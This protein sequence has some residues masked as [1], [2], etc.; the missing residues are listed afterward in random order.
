MNF[1]SAPTPS[2][3]EEFYSTFIASIRSVGT[4]CTLAAV[5]IYLHRQGYVVGD[6]KRSLALI[7]QQ[8]TI[9][10]FLFTKLI[11]CNQDWSDQPCPDV[12]KSLEDVWILMIWP[13]YVVITGLAI[14]WVVAKLSNTP[15]HQIHAVL[16]ACAFGNSTGLPITLLTVVHENFPKTSDLGRIDPN[17][18]LSVYLLLYPVLQ[19]G[20]GGW[21]LAPEEN[22]TNTNNNNNNHHD[23]LEQQQ[24]PAST[25]ITG[26]D[27]QSQ[28][29]RYVTNTDGLGPLVSPPL[30]TSGDAYADGYASSFQ[31]FTL[32][33]S[34]PKLLA[35]NVLNNRATANFYKF[36][37]RGMTET[38]ASLYMSVQEDLYLY[39]QMVDHPDDLHSDGASPQVATGRGDTSSNNH[40]MADGHPDA[41]AT[42]DGTYSTPT[43]TPST[44]IPDDKKSETSSLLPPSADNNID[45][46]FRRL[47][48]T[49]S[50]MAPLPRVDPVY[51]EETIWTTLGSICSRALQ[52]PVIGAVTGMIIAATP[53]R[54][55][56]VDTV[57]R[58]GDAPLQWFFDGLHEV[59]LA[60]VPLNMM[61]LG[62]NLSASASRLGFKS[63]QDQGNQTSD[64]DTFS[65]STMA[66]IVIGKMLVSPLVGF[67][68]AIILRNFILNIPDGTS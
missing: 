39:G 11:N 1:S 26:G 16:A 36:T 33:T 54:Q 19:W 41:F 13:A 55:I 25:T 37:R 6:G 12:T 61:I 14:G 50:M 63:Q 27:G 31:S 2:Y 28:S 59:G 4:A 17:L 32:L 47:S 65:H 29:D 23:D 51:E 44:V 34:S 53:L 35:H 56:F 48:K 67:I 52:P 30:S 5:G 57:D 60:A 49:P 15:R 42:K 40:D 20:V 10:L 45:A 66:A 7:S 18:F 62:C 46:T 43:P 22:N 64:A 24:D 8:V 68:S 9:P 38:D 58:D 21:L 3:S